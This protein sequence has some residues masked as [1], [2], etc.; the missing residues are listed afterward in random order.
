M[1]RVATLNLSRISARRGRCNE[2]RC[3]VSSPNCNST[4]ARSIHTNNLFD[5]SIIVSRIMIYRSRRCVLP[6]HMRTRATVSRGPGMHALAA[7]GD[8]HSSS[9]ATFLEHVWLARAYGR[10]NISG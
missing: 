7:N 4:V 3:K 9:V 5:L 8:W 6:L 2:Q 10:S 1:Q